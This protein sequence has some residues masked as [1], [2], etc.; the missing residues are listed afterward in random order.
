MQVLQFSLTLNDKALIQSKTEA[1]NN[2]TRPYA[3][4]IMDAAIGN[5]MQ[6]KK[7]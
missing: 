6:G 7:I 5:A 3:E 2:L 1:L 4:R